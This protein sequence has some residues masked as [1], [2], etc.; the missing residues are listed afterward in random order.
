MVDSTYEVWTNAVREAADIVEVIGRSVSLKQKGKKFWGLCPFHQEKTPSFSVDSHQQLFYCFG[1]HKGGTVFTF[2]MEHDGLT[3]IEAVDMLAAEVGIP[4]GERE[5]KSDFHRHFSRLQAVMEWS[6][7]F[8]QLSTNQYHDIFG[9][10]LESRQIRPE[11][12]KQFELGYA[13]KSWNALSQFLSRHGVSE[14]EMIEAGV[15]TARKEG[16]GV[17]DRWRQRI[18]FPIR[19][20]RGQLIGFGGRAIE[21]DQEPKYLNSPETPL[22]HKS[23]VLYG[24]HSA[25]KFWRQGKRPLLVEGYFDVIACHEAGL[26][27]AVASLGTALSKEHA[28]VL[29]RY[30]QEADL[31]YDS[32][33]AGQEAMSRAFFVLSQEGVKVNRVFLA[34]GKDP[35]EFLR[36]KGSSALAESVERRIPYFEA[37][38]REQLA[39]PSSSLTA[40]GK[41]DLVE[42]IKP[43]WKALN[44]PVEKSGYVEMMAKMLQVDQSILAQSFGMKQGNEHITPKNRHNMERIISNVK[45]RSHDVYLLAFLVRHPEHVG[46]VRETLPEWIIEHDLTKILEDLEQGA[47]VSE[48]TSQIDSMDT[49]VRSLM[50]EALAYDGPNGGARAVED[51]LKAIKRQHGIDRWNQLMARLKQGEN[52]PELFR[53][54]QEVQGQLAE[55]QLSRASDPW[56]A[57]RIGKEG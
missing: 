1:C 50:L 41:A 33:Q 4:R 25:R 27:Q 2:L 56:D 6:Q 47:S 48:L 40:R 34:S 28:R 44:D 12:Q 7:E 36:E 17:Y 18:M 5:D 54:I 37:V 11:A 49:N 16:N 43:Y 38:L 30:G 31:L 35:D 32:D 45:R 3:F 52:S 24:E 21:A 53:E 29:A 39:E 20:H 19:N 46:K 15:V 22:F 14:S 51:V 26:K 9:Q 55:D 10:Y 8:F 57:A 23:S 42:T 13:P